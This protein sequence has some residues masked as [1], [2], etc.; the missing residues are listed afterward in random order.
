M[1]NIIQKITFADMLFITLFVILGILEI[2]SV[3]VSYFNYSIGFSGLLGHIVFLNFIPLVFFIIR[4]LKLAFFSTLIIALLVIP[5]QIF[6]TYQLII[7]KEESSNIVAYIYRY[8]LENGEFPETLE[9][10]EFQ[11]PQLK[12]NIQ[13]YGSSGNDFQLRY[14]VGTSTTCYFIQHNNPKKWVYV[15]D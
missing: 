8:K 12:E 1:K 10:Y 11:Y 2:L 6:L 14:H 7:I 15:D 5:Y 13:H 9:G 3:I 4:K